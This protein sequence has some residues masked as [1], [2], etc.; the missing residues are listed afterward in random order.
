MILFAK[1]Y[2]L[3]LTIEKEKWPFSRNVIFNLFS[4]HNRMV[5]PQCRNLLFEAEVGLQRASR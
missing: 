5:N 3:I 2:S 1:M 4:C